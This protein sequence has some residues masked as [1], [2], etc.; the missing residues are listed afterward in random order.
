MEAAVFQSLGELPSAVSAIKKNKRLVSHVFCVCGCWRP[1]SLLCV[2]KQYVYL[3]QIII[4]QIIR[5][6]KP[7]EAGW[8]ITWRYVKINNVSKHN[9][10]LLLM[11]LILMTNLVVAQQPKLKPKKSPIITVK[12]VSFKMIY[13]VGG[14]FSMGGT[15]EQGRD[16]YYSEP[17]HLVSLST[18]YIGETEVTQELWKAVMGDNPS[19]FKDDQRPVEQV[20]WDDCQEFLRKLNEFTGLKFRL[21]TEAEWEFAARGGEKSKGYKYSGSNDIDAVAWYLGNSSIKGKSSPDY[22]THLVKTKKPNELGIY[23]MTGN[24]LEWCS[25]WY[26]K[27]TYK[28]QS[29]PQGPSTGTGRVRRGAGWTSILWSC[30]TSNRYHDTPDTRNNYLGLRLVLVP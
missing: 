2:F 16:Q 1:L 4:K 28:S 18:Y 13:V 29:D 25:D 3:F 9:G 17:V 21:P 8:D 22:G 11:L 30:P 15:Y 23:D 10:L 20:S 14:T 5:V 12:D 7:D 26:D 27:Y 24:V 19:Y 6:T